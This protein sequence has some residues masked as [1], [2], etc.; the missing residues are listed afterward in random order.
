[1]QFFLGVGSCEKFY[2]FP[3]LITIIVLFYLCLQIVYVSLYIL[4]S[5]CL[6]VIL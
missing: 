6:L 5:P 3:Q 1:M 4:L 2:V